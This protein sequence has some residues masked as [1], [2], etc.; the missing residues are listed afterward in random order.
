MSHDPVTVTVFTRPGCQLCDEALA[1]LRAYLADPAPAGRLRAVTIEEVDIE[2]DEDLHRRYLERI[3]VIELEGETVCELAF[4]AGR[5]EE[6]LR[7]Q[8]NAA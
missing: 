1:S 4:E 8:G 3:P 2:T 6:A 5:F 7:R